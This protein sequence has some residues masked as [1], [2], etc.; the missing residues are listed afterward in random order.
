MSTR[1]SAPK[2]APCWTDL[3]TSNV[4]R[5]REFYARLFGW[6]A[7]EPSEEFGGYFMF[8]RSGAPIAGGMGDMGDMK[9][10]D[11]WSIYLATDDI[12]EVVRQGE[13]AGAHFMFPPTPVADMG[14]QTVFADPSG[15][16]L[17]V[18]QPGTFHGFSVLEESGSPSWFELH[19]KDYDAALSFYTTVF[20]LHAST[21]SDTAEFRYSTLRSPD[22][23]VEVAGVFD[24]SKN[25]DAQSCWITYWDI[26]D[27]DAAL[28]RV[29]EL[30][31]SVLEGPIDSPYGRIATV[32]DPQGAEF[33]LRSQVP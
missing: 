29:A 12:E 13:A 26:D 14:V 4:Q 6:E 27:I 15:A 3:W 7:Q 19:T 30:G 18:W 20:H 28:V 23:D 21:M 25:A 33:K 22:G 2:G 17:G 24:I 1:S 9:A 16:M 32:A 31:G 11:K 5:S 8:N 10:N